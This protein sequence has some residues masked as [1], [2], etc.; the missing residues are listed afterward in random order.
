[1]ANPSQMELVLPP[2]EAAG[3]LTA[4]EAPGAAEARPMRPSL[5]GRRDL[6]VA[7][8]LC[9]AAVGVLWDAWADIYRIGTTD[10]ECSYVLLAP[11]VVFCLGWVRRKELIK[12]PVRRAWAGLAVLALG[13][14]VFWHGYVS[15]PVIWRAGAVMIA[16]GAFVAAV[17]LDV[18]WKL[19]PA[20]AACVF[21]VPVDPNGRYRLA[22]PMQV[23]TAQAAQH[24]CDI[25]GMY[26]QRSGNLLSVNGVGVTVAEACNGMRMILT[27]L[28]VCYLV[29]FSTPMPTWVRVPFLM[30]SP[31][32]A[33]VA[34]VAR[35]VPTVWM[36][37]HRS[38]AAAER[39]HDA[40]GW[41]MLVIAFL[42]LMGVFRLIRR[43]T[44]P[45]YAGGAGP[46]GVQ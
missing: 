16:V 18:S 44:G 30:L 12:Q 29:A 35:L 23:V 32:V 1:V 46:R 28:M 19:W 17:G 5:F 24:V 42:L 38:A 26:V 22:E 11:L 15:D 25:L 36:F 14:G 10:E 21:L 45:V 39:F 20:L 33:I 4:A 43:V 7:A 40:S 9:A 31:L 27:L 8:V 34:N 41:V 37:G 6:A 2:A 3:G 13:W